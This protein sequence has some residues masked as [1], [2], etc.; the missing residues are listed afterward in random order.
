LGKITHQVW[1]KLERSDQNDLLRQMI[2]RVVVVNPEGMIIPLELL[3][4]SVTCG[5]EHSGYRENKTS[6]KAGQGSDYI[7]S[8]DPNRKEL[9]HLSSLNPH[10][11]EFLQCIAF[12][13][14]A[15]FALLET[16]WHQV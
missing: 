5:M 8:S 3:S 7:L 14:N 1:D 4:P 2:E 15:Q 12:P 16:S 6:A 11:I 9:E 10:L 13:Q